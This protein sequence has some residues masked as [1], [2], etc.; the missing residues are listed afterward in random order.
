MDKVIKAKVRVKV[1]TEFGKWCLFEIRGLKEGT[2]L[3]GRFN[4]RNNAFDFTWNGGDAMLWVG[5]NA[6]IIE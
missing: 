5:H 4:P 2:E 3:E 6:E 1:F